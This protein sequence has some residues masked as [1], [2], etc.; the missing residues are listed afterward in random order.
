M[1]PN[2]HIV[3]GGT[4]KLF[5]VA[6]YNAKAGEKIQHEAELPPFN[7]TCLKGFLFS[8]LEAAQETCAKMNKSIKF[9]LKK[10]I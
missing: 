2:F 6:V 3:W 9:H 4:H 8:T 5:E 7:S 1:K 10:A